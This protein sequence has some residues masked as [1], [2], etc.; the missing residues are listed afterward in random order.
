LK[1]QLIEILI[2]ILFSLLIPAMHLS[3][4]NKY[5]NNGV[6][7]LFV[8]VKFVFVILIVL[9]YAKE[10]CLVSI[11]YYIEPLSYKF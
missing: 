1:L 11:K 3:F 7:L 4:K 8:E 5:R 9:I 10:L 2:Q 6:L